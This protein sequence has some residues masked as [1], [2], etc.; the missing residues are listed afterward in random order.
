MDK[1]LHY[2]FKIRLFQISKL[3]SNKEFLLKLRMLDKYAV[4]IEMSVSID[5]IPQPPDCAK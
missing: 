1:S 2:N 4:E 3:M 5:H